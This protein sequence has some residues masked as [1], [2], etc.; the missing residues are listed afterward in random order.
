MRYHQIKIVERAVGERY[1]TAG[2][3]IMANYGDNPDGLFATYTVLDK[4][5]INPRS[6]YSTPIGIY[7]Y[8]LW[9][10][11]EK[12]DQSGTAQGVD[13]MGDAPYIN[14]FKPVRPE[15]GW[16]L[17]NYNEADYNADLEKL[18]A[19]FVT[20]KKMLSAD[21]FEE[22]KAK[23][24][25]NAH[26]NKNRQSSYMWN[27]TRVFS[28][29]VANG[30]IKEHGSTNEALELGADQLLEWSDSYR[31]P[32]AVVV[33][34]GVMR[35]ILKYDFVSD[36]DGYGIIHPA[37][38]TQAVFLSKQG[39]SVIDRIKNKGSAMRHDIALIKRIGSDNEDD[40][41]AKARQSYEFEKLIAKNINNDDA[42]RGLLGEFSNIKSPRLQKRLIDKNPKY[43]LR[44]GDI[45]SDIEA[46]G[47]KK[48]IDIIKS[49]GQSERRQKVDVESL[50]MEYAYDAPFLAMGVSGAWPEFEEAAIKYLEKID[51]S[52]SNM[53]DLTEKYLKEIKQEPWAELEP[54]LRKS[55]E[56]WRAYKKQFNIYQDE[57]EEIF[58]DDLVLV[59]VSGTTEVGRVNRILD[60]DEANNY[61]ILLLRTNKHVKVTYKQLKLLTDERK[62]KFAEELTYTVDDPVVTTMDAEFPIDGKVYSIDFPYA[63][64]KESDWGHMYT[65]FALHLI[66]KDKQEVGPNL[67][68]KVGSNAR[69][70]NPKA[71]PRWTV[72]AID[73]HNQTVTL[74]GSNNEKEVVRTFDQFYQANPE[75]APDDEDEIDDINIDDVDFDQSNDN[76]NIPEFMIDLLGN[77]FINKAKNSGSVTTDDVKTTIGSLNMITMYYDDIIKTF[78][79]MG[80]NI[81]DDS[82]EEFDV[83]ID[84]E[85]EE[86]PEDYHKNNVAP[87]AA[88]PSTTPEVNM[89]N[90]KKFLYGYQKKGTMSMSELGKIM[91]IGIS[92]D[93]VTAIMNMAA[94][95][96]IELTNS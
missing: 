67:K 90:V 65:V 53:Y 6:G 2:D 36:N 10:V 17:D 52:F 82:D 55:K 60:N 16:N 46:Y 77:N 30:T 71:P 31:T 4:V 75:Y 78:N 47:Q 29:A 74:I 35:N 24:I 70:T 38:K 89:D 73:M 28:Q 86:E 81:I 72:T 40:P 57:D 92:L 84:F 88:K 69:A 93:D 43:L 20:Q 39:L 5:G 45:N 66:H 63:K 94:S 13:Y 91:P 87:K 7:C 49:A 14:I 15:A 59:D 96:K 27:I 37:E 58:R 95:M 3:E 62:D 26:V 42:L 21:G 22:I 12:I 61:D 80:V 54:F 25:Y 68:F 85:P 51:S 11:V 18:E 64:V 41:N 79:Q 34:N 48:F 56:R 50:L 19:Y 76:S 8:P 33:W 1:K 23:A 32:R 44:F 9:Y 83:D